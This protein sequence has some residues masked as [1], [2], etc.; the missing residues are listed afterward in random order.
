MSTFRVEIL[1]KL[2]RSAE[3]ILLRGLASGLKRLGYEARPIAV[4]LRNT[5][6]DP[7]EA[8]YR[9]GGRPFLINLPLDKARGLNH[10]AFPC[11]S[12]SKHPFIA[13]ARAHLAGTLKNDRRSPLEQFYQH[14]TPNSAAEVLGLL[15]DGSAALSQSPPHGAVLPWTALGPQDMA[16]SLAAAV[17]KENRSFNRHFGIEEGC[18]AS[19]RMSDRKIELEY[20]RLIDVTE[21]IR[22][23]GF[24]CELHG[25][26]RGYLL[27]RDNDYVC[28]IN[29]GQHRI[30]ALAALGYVNIPVKIRTSSYVPTFAVHRAD[31]ESWPNVKKGLFSVEQ[32]LKIFD[33][34]F[35]GRQ[36]TNIGHLL[37]YV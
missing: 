1:K 19:G 4:D 21:S 35:E 17:F 3:P 27:I 33:R 20:V 8:L 26:V 30:A 2:R 15:D 9:S 34:I 18:P 5:T 14:W 24:I 28:V 6:D 32:A 12:G 11:T 22:K 31:V 7:I 13:T 25:F 37:E 36:S 23:K 10:L 16:K 29:K